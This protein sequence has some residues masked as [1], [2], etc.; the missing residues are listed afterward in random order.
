M[1]PAPTGTAGLSADCGCTDLELNQSRRNKEAQGSRG[2]RR[3]GT[4]GLSDWQVLGQGRKGKQAREVAV[5]S[6]RWGQTG[7]RGK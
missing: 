5:P 1:H 6:G 2:C 7:Q 3:H 4:D